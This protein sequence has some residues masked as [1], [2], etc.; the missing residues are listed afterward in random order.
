MSVLSAACSVNASSSNHYL[1]NVEGLAK[2][3]A[4]VDKQSECHL[5]GKLLQFH[6]SQ[7]EHTIITSLLPSLV[8]A[9]FLWFNLSSHRFYHKPPLPKR[10][11]HLELCVFQE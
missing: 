10:R 2:G 6:L 5:S 9:A 4:S 11:R 8:I 7:I 1:Q 3:K